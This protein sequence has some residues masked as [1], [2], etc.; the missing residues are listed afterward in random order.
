MK[1]GSH[2]RT[3]TFD[4]PFVIFGIIAGVYFLCWIAWYSLHTQ[5]STIYIYWRYIELWW[6][7]FLGSLVDFPGVTDVYAWLERVCHPD[8]IL[9]LCRQNFS[10]IELKDITDSSW[11]MNLGLMVPLI[12][13][14]V[15]MFRVANIAHPKL[16]YVRIHTLESFVREKKQIYPHLRMFSEIDLISEPLD[17]PVFGMSLTSRQ[18][19]FKYQ[20]I[21]GWK[22]EV[23]GSFA[24]TLDRV[25]AT[26]IFRAQLGKHWTKSTELSVGET[27]LVAISIP[28]VV[29][30]DSSLEDHA[31]EE[32]M[33][34][35]EE[36]TKWCWEQFKAPAVNEETDDAQKRYAW[37]QPEIDL[38]KPRELILKYIAHPHVQTILEKHAYIRT[39]IIALFIQARRLGVLQPAEMRWMR[40]FDREL[41]YILETIGRQAT[42]AEAAGVLSHYLYEIKTDVALAEPQLDKAVNGLEAAINN[43]KFSNEDRV[44]YQEACG[45]GN[46]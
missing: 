36:L 3:V 28:R 34:E 18:F 21:A 45:S 11:K 2:E 14:C 24:P 13:L 31:F 25:K 43:F 40:F 5:F 8:G 38:T 6:L 17:H 32:A 10:T 1:Q 44:R 33:R 26:A 41:W 35:S 29:A 7:H 23:G 4:D 30:S 27:L 22:E 42:F 39:V 46:P 20:L 9:G 19:V 12:T 15:Y 37:L 16:K